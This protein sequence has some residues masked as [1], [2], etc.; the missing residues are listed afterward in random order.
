[1]RVV[2]GVLL[3]LI[4]GAAPA[5][6]VLGEP[7]ASVSADRQFLR[8]QIRDEAH[9]GYRLHQITYSSGA[10]VREY[11]S[12][13]G[14]VFGVSWQGPRVPNMQQ[15]LGSYFTYLQQYAQAQTGR[16]GGPLIIQKN[17]FVFSSGGHM[18]SY[19]GRAYLPSLLPTNLLPEV[20]Q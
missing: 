13:A 6:A 20:V 11:V 10:V 19:H 15:L 18:R 7:E 14:K 9:E 17:D 5:W 8:G 3:I 4:L 12:P 1:M 2:W 16:H